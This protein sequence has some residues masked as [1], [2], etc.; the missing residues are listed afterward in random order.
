MHRQSPNWIHSTTIFRCLLCQWQ[1]IF[2]WEPHPYSVKMSQGSGRKEVANS[3]Q[4]GLLQIHWN[5]ISINEQATICIHIWSYMFN[6]V[7]TFFLDVCSE[8]SVFPSLQWEVQG[9]GFKRLP[10]GGQKF[11]KWHAFVQQTCRIEADVGIT[12]FDASCQQIERCV[13]IYS[14]SKHITVYNII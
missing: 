2:L 12:L 6:H 5:S 1:L 13:Y 7:H 3:P 8:C 10:W 9:V 11:F 4:S 14:I